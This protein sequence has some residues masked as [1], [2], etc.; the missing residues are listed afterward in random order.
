MQSTITPTPAG[1]ITS[2]VSTMLINGT[3]TQSEISFTNARPC[4]PLPPLVQTYFTSET[5]TLQVCAVIFLA[6]PQNPSTINVNYS[7]DTDGNP[8][9]VINYDDSEIEATTFYGY[10][11]NFDIY[12]AVKPST[13]TVFVNDIDPNTSRGTEVTVQP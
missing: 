2:T 13:I 8:E 5:G 11:V 7:L 10:Q 4:R 3:T 6:Q 9:F 12:L 1:L